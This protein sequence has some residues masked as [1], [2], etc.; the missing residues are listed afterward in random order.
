MFKHNCSQFTSTEELQGN[1]FRPCEVDQPLSY[2]AQHFNMTV[3]AQENGN[4]P[5]HCGICK[6]FLEDADL[7]AV[8]LPNTI[9]AVKDMVQKK[10]N[11]VETAKNYKP[12]K[13][14]RATSAD[15]NQH[16][17]KKIKQEVKN[18]G[19]VC[20]A[21]ATEQK[22]EQLEERMGKAELISFHNLQVL[23]KMPDLV[24]EFGEKSEGTKKAITHPIYCKWCNKT[25]SGRNRAKIAQHTSGQEHRRRWRSQEA[26]GEAKAVDEDV[27]AEQAEGSPDP[28]PLGKCLGLRLQGQLGRTTRLGSDLFPVWQTYTQ[29]AN[30]DKSLR[31]GRNVLGTL[32][33]RVLMIMGYDGDI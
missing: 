3:A 18:E 15:P 5:A 19:T 11:Q 31:T 7:N 9:A 4:W 25:F 24:D 16:A 33:K 14:K 26:L 22:V 21:E 8:L 13:V 23:Q 12:L 30:L 32:W 29:Y 27:K 6:K 1:Y 10:I 20:K 17:E 28:L 2:D